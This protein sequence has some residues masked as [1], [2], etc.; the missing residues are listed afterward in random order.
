MKSGYFDFPRS[1]LIFLGGKFLSLLGD[2]I[3]LLVI[4]WII[5]DLTGSALAIGINY[6]L[7]FI[8]NWTLPFMGAIVD[9]TN[10]KLWLIYS[11][12]A[13]AGIL[14][15]LFILM[16]ADVL[17][18][19]Q[20]YVSAFVIALLDRTEGVA[21][22]A[23]APQLIEPEQ[24]THYNALFHNI[25][26]ISWYV[27]PLLGGAI[28]GLTNPQTAL[29]V[30][31]LTYGIIMLTILGLTLKPTEKL[32]ERINWRELVSGFEFI[33]K[34]QILIQLALLL[35]FW[36]ATWGGVYALMI[37]FFRDALA[38]SA[39]EIGIIGF[40]GGAV[41]IFQGII[42]PWILSKFHPYWV[43]VGGIAMSGVAMAL[44]PFSSGVATAAL[45]VAFM[46]GPVVVLTVIMATAR[47]TLAPA[48][49]LGKVTAASRTISS[50]ITPVVPLIS[51]A[52]AEQWDVTTVMVVFGMLTV[53]G[54][55]AT[56]WSALPHV[57]LQPSAET[58]G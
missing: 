5:Y 34:Q 11:N 39:F 40:V 33:W 35:L 8:P 12:L 56:R 47:Q 43:L 51:G 9:R 29:L 2:G 3:F 53:I 58:Y 24:Y 50:S 52:L 27:G 55:V 38:L 28:I 49:I 30:D 20:L 18:L 14:G 26:A 42:S 31:G 15:T 48:N 13:R 19:W 10:R 45:I 44:L 57:D 16:S 1:L 22:E 36:N 46:D 25:D 7:F 37:F 32:P 21:L 54:A 4:P 6:A 41:P 17:Q 23:I